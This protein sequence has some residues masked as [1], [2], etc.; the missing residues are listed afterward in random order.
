MC[1]VMSAPHDNTVTTLIESDQS[2]HVVT[3]DCW[4]PTLAIPST[5]TTTIVTFRGA[6]N[7][8]SNPRALAAA[9][10]LPRHLGSL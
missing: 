2:H 8:T 3:D 5:T 10:A 6:V 1:C 9:V 7:I 4:S